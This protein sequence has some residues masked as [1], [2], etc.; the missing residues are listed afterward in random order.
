[1]ITRFLPPGLLLSTLM[2]TANAQS[3]A[4]PAT[5]PT[6]ITAA[7]VSGQWRASKLVGLDI[8]N[9]QDEKLGDVSEIL[10][11]PSGKVT[12]IIIGVG[13]FLGIG[14]RDISVSLDQLKFVNEPRRVASN[15][16]AGTGGM[17]PS[18]APTTATRMPTEKWYP[19]H[20]ILSGATKESLKSRPEF[21]YD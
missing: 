2:V 10:L 15:A 13:G 4:P 12:G 9:D 21:K 5:A 16:P 6:T 14:K 19:D 3:P 1:M 17:A 7:S 20:A 11:D 18:P 8:Y